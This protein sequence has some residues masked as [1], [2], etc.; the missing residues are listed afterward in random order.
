MDVKCLDLEQGVNGM[1]VST[2][3]R[4][5]SSG[6][7]TED[8]MNTSPTGREHPVALD[9]GQVVMFV[10]CVD[11]NVLSRVLSSMSNSGSGGN[12]VLADGVLL[13]D[14]QG[15]F[16]VA[17]AGH[18][19]DHSTI[20]DV[21]RQPQVKENCMQMCTAVDGSDNRNLDFTNGGCTLLASPCATSATNTATTE[22]ECVQIMANVLPRDQGV[23]D[24]LVNTTSIDTGVSAQ[25]S[26]HTVTSITTPLVS[27]TAMAAASGDDAMPS[28]TMVTSSVAATVPV[29]IAMV[30]V[31][32]LDSQISSELT[33]VLDLDVKPV[34]ANSQT[35]ASPTISSPGLQTDVTAT[36]QSVASPSTGQE[37]LQQLQQQQQQLQQLQQ[38]ISSGGLVMVTS[39]NPQTVFTVQWLFSHFEAA[40][41]MSLPR[42]AIFTFYSE[43]CKQASIQP[44]NSASFG[45]AMRQVFPNIKTRRLG[46][47]GQSRYHYYGV[48]VRTAS[49]YH[50]LMDAALKSCTADSIPANIK[51]EASE[52]APVA[53][54]S[55]YPSSPCSPSQSSLPMASL[56][57]SPL[58]GFPELASLQLPGEV[59][60]E[61]VSLWLVLYKAHCQRI[62]D[63]A[64]AE[65]FTEVENYIVNFWGGLPENLRSLLTHKLLADLIGVCDFALY[66]AILAAVVPDPLRTLSL[67]MTQALKNFSVMFKSWI[68]AAMQHFPEPVLKCKVEVAKVFLSALRRRMSVSHLAQAISSILQSSD[69][70]CQMLVDWQQLHKSSIV[71]QSLACCSSKDELDKHIP[72]YLSFMAEF[73]DLLVQQ[74]DVHSFAFW[75]SSVVQRILEKTSNDVLTSRAN[76][77]A[78][79]RA[80]MMR[81]QFL[82]SCVV[83]DLTL[84][85]SESFG[86]HHL[87]SML[88][89]DYLFYLLEKKLF[90]VHEQELMASVQKQDTCTG[91]V[92]SAPV[93]TTDA[94]MTASSPVST[95]SNVMVLQASLESV[96]RDATANGDLSSPVANALPNGLSTGLLLNGISDLADTSSIEPVAKLSCGAAHSP[97]SAVVRLSVPLSVAAQLPVTTAAVATNTVTCENVTSG[98]TA[99]THLLEVAGSKTSPGSANAISSLLDPAS[100]MDL[101]GVAAIPLSTTMSEDADAAATAAAVNDILY[102]AGFSF[103][104]LSMGSL[105]V[106][107]EYF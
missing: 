17:P 46:T 90:E 75:L 92:E 40:E 101:D 60:S 49:P 72:L 2:D 36:P 85:S 106:E 83:R 47:R 43:C 77:S 56:P 3:V 26:P 10:D 14:A 99:T 91:E 84:Q 51:L 98:D 25:D 66:K 38:Q 6:A 27:P 31:P 28:V 61:K 39:P 12:G 18:S 71:Y 67:S 21:S 5:E 65:N 102:E 35:D 73:E 52:P 45:K 50:A 8:V 1:D 59:S 44:V 96:L 7:S 57:S 95:D 48:G 64:I 13:H 34:V 19:H 107:P 105:A 29:D 9:D 62:L 30:D 32:Q 20:E 78:M 15:T 79:T 89:G 88:L 68:L 53:A 42:H 104:E 93:E 58:P 69:S 16:S 4:V 100:K 70:V 81:W 97:G 33:A 63:A 80:F 55:S 94:K 74:A 86:S 54:V 103:P 41:H 23:L 37:E 76:L 24:C 82:T 22:P 87:L 11:G